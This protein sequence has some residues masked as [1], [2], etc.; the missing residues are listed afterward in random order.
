MNVLELFAGTR[1]I[2][3]AFEAKGHEVFSVEWGKKFKDIDLYKDILQLTADEI[4]KQ[5]GKPDV[6]W[7]SPDCTT[8]SISAI[9]HHRRKNPDTARRIPYRTKRLF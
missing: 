6:V 5:F 3:Q 8:F 9:S 2:G 4:L 7:L 1:S